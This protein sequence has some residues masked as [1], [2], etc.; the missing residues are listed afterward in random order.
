MKRVL[1]LL[2]ILL[3]VGLLA[4]GIHHRL[5]ISAKRKREADYQTRLRLF[6][7]ALKP[8][9]TRKQVEDYLRSN[10]VAYRQEC[11]VV[12]EESAARHSWDELVKLGEEDKPW[13]CSAN[14]VYLAF[15]FAD[16]RKPRAK[17]QFEDD[18][19]DTLRSVT[20]YNQMEGCL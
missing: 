19:M 8:G 17:S 14:S 16:S 6:A 7:Q 10:N 20:I 12:A 5:Q 11:C 4:W 3:A 13:Y 9:V 18:D 15:R 2:L 1:P